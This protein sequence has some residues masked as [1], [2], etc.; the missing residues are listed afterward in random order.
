MVGEWVSRTFP[1]SHWQTQVRLG[2][3]QPRNPDGKF[4]SEEKRMLGLWRR[5][6]DCIVYL[7]DRLLLVEAV[8]GAKPGKISVL[9]LY[10]KLVPQTPEL[11]EYHH[12]PVQLV[13]LY[14]IEDPVLNVVAREEGILP[15]RF[16]P[17]FFDEWLETLAP[18]HRRAPLST[19]AE[20][21]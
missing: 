13:F 12:L 7:P 11:A 6:I 14:A 17:S 9:K 5:R 19:F 20:G 3:I 1:H 2:R 4:T 18:R 21:P 16:V 8:L 15:I 10:G